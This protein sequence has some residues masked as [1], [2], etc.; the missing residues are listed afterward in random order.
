MKTT[1]YNLV[2]K[3]QSKMFRDCYIEKLKELRKY[4]SKVGLSIIGLNGI[5]EKNGLFKKG[6]LSSISK[7]LSTDNSNTTVIDGF[8]SVLN[9]TEDIGYLLESNPSVEDLKNIKMYSRIRE[10][11]D[12]LKCKQLPKFLG[13]IGYINKVLN[14]ITKKDKDTRLTETLVNA[15][16][17]IVIY[18]SGIDDLTRELNSDPIKFHRD[19]LN[20][21]GQY[22]YTLTKINDHS[23]VKKVI[24]N[25]EQSFKNILSYNDNVTLF[26]IG[27]NSHIEGQ[28]Y[29]I[30]SFKKVINEYNKELE[31]LCCKYG[32]D[33]VPS[34]RNMVNMI[35]DYL[36]Y[37][38]T[39]DQEDYYRPQLDSNDIEEGGLYNILCE[40]KHDLHLVHGL[41]SDEPDFVKKQKSMV[42]R[43]KIDVVERT[44]SKK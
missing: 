44:I 27:A 28:D 34:H 43:R 2:G 32:F 29:E 30:K 4:Y 5:Q 12:N 9:T 39:W 1:N 11:E 19:Y 8:S 16:E 38:K 35:I 10:L 24:G 6:L 42:L 37:K 25:V 22:K 20:N 33:Y 36:Y 14:P 15:S 40:L 41:N 18:A 21:I 13:K 23:A 3:D 26:A 31:N 17:P 7:E